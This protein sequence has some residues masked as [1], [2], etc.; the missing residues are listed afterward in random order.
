MSTAKQGDFKVPWT[1]STSPQLVCYP[2]TTDSMFSNH[3]LYT[4]NW[5]YSYMLVIFPIYIFYLSLCTWD[6]CV[7]TCVI[8]Q[9]EILFMCPVACNWRV[10]LKQRTIQY[11]T[12]KMET[13]RKQCDTDESRHFSVEGV[14]DVPAEQ[15]YL[16][17][18]QVREEQEASLQQEWEN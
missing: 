6:I 9:Y 5:C 7:F 1:K 17:S 16:E 11:F 12:E 15:N 10:F 8:S 4:T 13:K 3:F 2:K 14:S 18:T